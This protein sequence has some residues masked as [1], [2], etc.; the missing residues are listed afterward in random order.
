MQGTLAYL[1]WG[2]FGLYFSLLA[3]VPAAEVLA[4]RVVWCL[5]VTFLLVSA[6]G[7]SAKLAAALRQPRIVGWLLVTSLLIGGN[8]WI[9]IWAV[10]QREVVQASLGYFL[11]PLV[12]VILGRLF[13]AETFNRLQLAAISLASVGVLWQVL[14]LGHFPWIAISLALLFGFYGLIR[15][16][17][18]VD[19]L[20]GL[21]IESALVTPVAL[22]YWYWLDLHALSHFAEFWPLL[23]G[24][25]VMTA[26]PLL[27]FASSARK[28]PLSTLGFLTYIAPT[29]Q[30]LSAVL[31]LNEPLSSNRLISFLFIWAGLILF[32]IN[33]YRMTQKQL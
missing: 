4:H 28:V 22:A 17:L 6:S 30:F 19:S 23:L 11:S 8:W 5:L 10:S 25:G 15:K 14:V 24:A 2:A 12:A 26:V 33:L 7:N 13:L 3:S 31:I 18:E 1:I 27:L 21:V 16:R 32:L 20:T 29:L 9:Y